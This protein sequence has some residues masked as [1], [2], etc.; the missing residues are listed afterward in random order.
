[1]QIISH[2]TV[3]ATCMNDVTQRLVSW[4]EEDDDRKKDKAKESEGARAEEARYVQLVHRCAGTRYAITAQVFERVC[5]SACVRAHAL[6]E[7]VDMACFCTRIHRVF[8]RSTGSHLHTTWALSRLVHARAFDL[9][10]RAHHGW[11]ERK[12]RLRIRLPQ[13]PEPQVRDSCS[14]GTFC[15]TIACTCATCARRSVQCSLTMSW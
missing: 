14:R 5:K 11:K 12:K 8:D 13:E 2:V 7:L 3:V 15:G 10:R 4:L 9:C 1:M 6:Q